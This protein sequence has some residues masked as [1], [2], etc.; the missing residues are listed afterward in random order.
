MKARGFTLVE[1]MLVIAVIGILAAVAFPVYQDYVI[2]TQAAA[3]YQEMLPAKAAIERLKA[4]RV[5]PSLEYGAGYI[6]VGEGKLTGD[7][8]QTKGSKGT[9]CKFVYTDRMGTIKMTNVILSCFIGQGY[10]ENINEKIKDKI[11]HITRNGPGRWTCTTN[12]DAKYTPSDCTK[13]F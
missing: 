12:M 7:A 1:I 9:Y 13:T 3:A 6:A 11:I 2:R 10:D 4:M 5:D 8:N